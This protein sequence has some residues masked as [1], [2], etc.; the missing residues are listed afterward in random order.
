MSY[1]HL[2]D[3]KKQ[4][5]VL[6]GQSKSNIGAGHETVKNTFLGG[7]RDGES[8]GL[9]RWLSKHGGALKICNDLE[10]I[11]QAIQK[12]NRGN[13]TTN[14]LAKKLRPLASN[15]KDK[16]KRNVP[17]PYQEL[18]SAHPY[19][20][21]FHRLESALCG[22]SNFDPEDDDVV[23]ID[24]ED[25]IEEVKT[26]INIKL[27]NSAGRKRELKIENENKKTSNRPS[28]RRMSS[29]IVQKPATSKN[30]SYIHQPHDEDEDSSDVEIVCIV[31]KNGNTSTAHNEN[32]HEKNTNSSR[33]CQSNSWICEQCQLCNDKIFRNR[34]IFCGKE[35]SEYTSGKQRIPAHQSIQSG[36]YNYLSAFEMA[37]KLQYLAKEIAK[38]GVP[39][40]QHTHRFWTAKE[41]YAFVLHLFVDF[42]QK[43]ESQRYIDPIDQEKLKS[44]GQP[45][46]SSIIVNPLC[47]R[48]I[49][50]SLFNSY[51]TKNAMALLS[52]TKLTWD[53]W[54]G[55]DLIEA[56][57]LVLLN[58]LA[59]YGKI[60]SSIRSNTLSLRNKFW[61]Q[62]HERVCGKSGRFLPIKRDEGSSFVVRKGYH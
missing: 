62:I 18:S 5:V 60:S 54:D 48:D 52:N 59:Y 50:N 58:S 21:F 8:W 38:D 41:N 13:E 28:K 43:Q 46:Y 47:F 29:Q 22:L 49:F 57:D 31:D 25:E 19:L 35:K 24:D 6:V 34:C 1:E 12:L 4:L 42:L 11:F 39:F 3:A 30:F 17:Q 2:L 53:M 56:M 27:N 51:E 36:Q 7:M 20:P 9:R 23:I 55:K 33:E 44:T 40:R 16:L 61:Y 26:Q 15:A 14:L 32:E 45:D 10:L 37:Q